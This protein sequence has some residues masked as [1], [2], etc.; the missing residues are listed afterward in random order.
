VPEP[1]IP[2]G[3]AEREGGAAGEPASPVQDQLQA[4]L[5][6]RDALMQ[7]WLLRSRFRQLPPARAERSR[8]ERRYAALPL[9]RDLLPILD[10]LHRALEAARNGGDVNQLVQGGAD[11]FEAVRR[12]AGEACRRCDR[13]TR[14]A[15]DPN[16]HQAIQQVPAPGKPP[17]TVVAEC[18]R[19]YR[20]H[21]RVVRPSTV[22]VSAPRRARLNRARVSE[23]QNMPTY[24]Y[25]CDACEHVWEEFQSMASKP[26][27]KC[28][29]C[30]KAK[31][32]RKIGPGAG[33]IFKGSGFYQTDYPA[34]RTRSLP[35]PIPSRRRVQTRSPIQSPVRRT[36]QQIAQVPR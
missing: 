25:V 18:E 31:A 8:T 9:A 2:A 13:R 10:N 24:D 22:I 36:R 30:G 12:R 15:F 6:E 20:M 23:G 28:P 4:A 21:E 33:I 29:E 1:E 35:R 7:K 3:D 5:S 26:T 17:L 16:L 14:S 27:K 19:G 11:G 34:I 32:R